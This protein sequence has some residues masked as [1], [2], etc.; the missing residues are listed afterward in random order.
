M[1][2]CGLL[3]LFIS[4][5][6]PENP[7]TKEESTWVDLSYPFDQNTIYWPTDTVG[8]QI[9]T[10][11][12]GMTEQQYFYCAYKFS[13]AEHGGTHLDAPV[14]FAKGSHTVDD[15]PL[16]SL[17][18]EAI[19]IDV[20]EAALNDADYL[21]SVSD[22]EQWESVHGPIPQDAIVLLRTGYGS[23]WPD[24]QRYLGTSAT[25]PEAVPQLHFPGLGPEAARWLTEQ[26]S[27]KAI[28]L[29]TPSIDHG[30]S[31]QFESHRIL[32]QHNIPAFENLANLDQL[33]MV[34]SWVVAL[35]M[36][37]AGGSGAPLRAIAR[38]PADG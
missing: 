22:F 28:G 37:I 7:V 27:I 16:T 17:V 4:C 30:Q 10:V 36:P 38:I 6:P 32:F 14:H 15:I 13:S 23:F 8:F 35:P 34:G 21:V 2:I 31:Q 33:P 12:H 19:V 20:S 26:R 29:D 25:G 9:D 1:K 3:M 5:Q 24:R 18:G 11:F